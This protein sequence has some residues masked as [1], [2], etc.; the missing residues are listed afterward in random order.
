M[1]DEDAGKKSNVGSPT[2]EVL[3]DDSSITAFA[4]DTGHICESP[5]RSDIKGKMSKASSSNLSY[6]GK[7]KRPW[8]KYIW[9]F[10]LNSGALRH[11]ETYTF[12]VEHS[13]PTG[14][15]LSR[16]VA[17]VPVTV[18]LRDMCSMTRAEATVKLLNFEL[19]DKLRGGL[20]QPDSTNDASSFHSM[21]S[22]SNLNLDAEKQTVL[23]PKMRR[24]VIKRLGHRQRAL[25]AQRRTTSASK[26][27]ILSS[28]SPKLQIKNSTPS[29]NIS[30]READLS[31]SL[32]KMNY[33]DKKILKYSESDNV[34]KRKKASSYSSE[35]NR[36][37]RQNRTLL[38]SFAR[39]SND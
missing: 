27:S 35:S 1:L 12:R 38:S 20:I 28:R 6:T 16:P 37:Q 5:S 26:R 30:F 10:D 22:E 23:P 33:S 34:G 36:I 11:G 8:C 17:S 21:D 29:R 4:S 2:L 31:T 15:F 9:R 13:D 32:E 18:P 19:I 14:R 24:I 25:H 39:G 3:L 7:E